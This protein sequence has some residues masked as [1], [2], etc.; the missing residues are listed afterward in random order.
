MDTKKLFWTGWKQPIDA[1]WPTLSRLPG[2][3]LGVWRSGET[4][5][6][7]LMVGMVLAPCEDDAKRI[8]KEH[9]DVTGWRFCEVKPFGESLG[10]R[11]ELTKEMKA[12]F[13]AAEKEHESAEESW[14]K[15]FRRIAELVSLGASWSIDEIVEEV[16]QLKEGYEE[17]RAD[18]G[19]AQCLVVSQDR[20][21]ALESALCL[22]AET[23]E[24]HK[25][26]YG[27][28]GSLDCT[29][30]LKRIHAA[31]TGEQPVEE[32]QAK[33]YYY[34]VEGQQRLHKLQA[35][36]DKEAVQEAKERAV[37]RHDYGNLTVVYR[38][39][40]DANKYLSVVFT[41]DD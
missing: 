27:S 26:S 18:A 34:A 10:D 25:P 7:A 2:D 20:V 33:T 38:E 22:A 8:V 19:A 37:Y 35:E 1:S 41:V 3:F 17:L 11:F 4:S 13:K 24:A 9:F 40:A 5:A 14:E 36:S 30:A 15:D 23:I 12:R 31:L 16:R 29:V 6:L 32:T 28:N 21:A 39:S